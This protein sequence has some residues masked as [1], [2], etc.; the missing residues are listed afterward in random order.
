MKKFELIDIFGAFLF[1]IVFVIFFQLCLYLLPII[2][3]YWIYTEIKDYI[4]KLKEPKP[5]KII[6][7]TKTKNCTQHQPFRISENEYVLCNFPCPYGD[8]IY[9]NTKYYEIK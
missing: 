4:K 1:L 2:L 6:E 8:C 5:L 3:V 7:Q 9:K